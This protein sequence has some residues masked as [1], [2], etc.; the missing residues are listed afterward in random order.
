MTTSH[1][2]DIQVGWRVFAGS[3]Q[4]GEVT[5]IRDDALEVERGRLRRHLYRFPRSL[6]KEATDGV[7]DLELEAGGIDEFEADDPPAGVDLPDEYRRL[8]FREDVTE[9]VVP[10]D[11]Q[12][13]LK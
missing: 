1:I 7:V 2:A 6:V 5:R 8:E 10:I 12:P 11:T 3:E 13:T 9:R 4:I